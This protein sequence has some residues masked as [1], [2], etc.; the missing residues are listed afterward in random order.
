[1]KKMKIMLSVV[2]VLILFGCGKKES[3]EPISLVG[4]WMEEEKSNY[5][6]ALISEE[7]MEIYQVAGDDVSLYWAGSVQSLENKKEPITWVSKR[8]ALKMQNSL[9]ASGLEEKEFTYENNTISYTSSIMGIETKRELK[10][11]EK[12]LPKMEMKSS[13]TVVQEELKQPE[14]LEIG[15]GLTKNGDYF[16]YGGILYNPNEK[17]TIK[18]ANYDITLTDSE[19]NIVGVESGITTEIGPKEQKVITGQISCGSS[20]LSNIELKATVSR[21][22][23]ISNSECI[24]STMFYFQQ[25]SILENYYTEIVGKLINNSQIETASVK[26]EVLCRKEGKIVYSDMTFL[27]HVMPGENVFKVSTNLS[28]I[29]FDAIE[30]Y[31]YDHSSYSH[32]KHPEYTPQTGLINQNVIEY[33]KATFNEEGNSATA[34]IDNTEE[35]TKEESEPSTVEVQDDFES[36]KKVMDEY[37]SF[38]DSYIEFLKTYDSSNPSALLKYMEVLQKYQSTMK[39][40]EDLKNKEMTPE[41]AEYYTQTMLRINQKLSEV[42]F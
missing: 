17:A 16:M 19:G 29:D 5:H 41:E 24:P 7:A 18:Y 42:A 22:N 23:F 8:D 2:I 12:E 31:A 9:F 4:N 26:I 3:S 13:T 34:S 40:L 35:K 6:F 1:M 28:D 11:T 27:D 36:F 32:I 38:F 39:A 25:P 10:R 33:K 15:G 14:V 37:E 20:Q 30:L 21:D